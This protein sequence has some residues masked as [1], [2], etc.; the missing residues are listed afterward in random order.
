VERTL[1][2]VVQYI[3]HDELAD[4]Q[5]RFFAN[6]LHARNSKFHSEDNSKKTIVALID[7]R[8][9]SHCRIL[10]GQRQDF[11]RDLGGN[12]CG[13]VPSLNGTSL[14]YQVAENDAADS[15][16]RDRDLKM[17]WL[18]AGVGS[19]KGRFLV[20]CAQSIRPFRQRS[21]MAVAERTLRDYWAG[22]K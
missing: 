15:S 17:A 10:V 11:S 3:S 14:R 16:Q 12:I 5:I 19:S 22:T 18:Q 4:K 6:N 13:G 21:K 7:G 8:P 20:I 9:T 1:G 2:F